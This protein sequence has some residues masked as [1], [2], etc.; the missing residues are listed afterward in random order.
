M[1]CCSP[2]SVAVQRARRNRWETNILT[3]VLTDASLVGIG[4]VLEWKHEDKWHPVAFWSPKLKDPETRYSATDRGWLAIVA[5]VTREWPWLLE[6]T[7]FEIRSD[8]KALESKLCKA[9]Q[10]PPL[11]D[12]QARWIEAMMHF[13]Y[14]FN[15]IKGETNVVTDA[16]SRHPT[17]SPRIP[18]IHD[19]TYRMTKSMLKAT[20]R[21]PCAQS[22]EKHTAERPAYLRTAMVSRIFAPLTWDSYRTRLHMLEE[23]GT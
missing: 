5:A 7:P 2:V 3:C 11:N 9:R 21:L 14:T 20:C 6:A 16:L 1:G 12:R 4:A 18:Q 15:W 23:W 8:H 22:C 13:P 19:V 10:D 17:V